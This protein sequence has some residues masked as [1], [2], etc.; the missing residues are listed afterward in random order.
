MRRRLWTENS[1]A[2]FCNREAKPWLVGASLGRE[3]GNL[4]L[5]EVVSYRKNIWIP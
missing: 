5:R 1:G 3:R 2:C 4:M